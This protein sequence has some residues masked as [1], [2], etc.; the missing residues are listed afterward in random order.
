MMQKPNI[1]KDMLAWIGFRI[2]WDWNSTF[3]EIILIFQVQVVSDT[4]KVAAD[5]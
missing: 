4:G 2:L 5:I 3:V 1:M